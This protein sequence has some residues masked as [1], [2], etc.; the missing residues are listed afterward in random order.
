MWMQQTSTRV[1]MQK[2]GK[3]FSRKIFSAIEKGMQNTFKKIEF[4][5]LWKQT[6]NDFT[7]NSR[8]GVEWHS[9]NI[10]RRKLHFN[11]RSATERCDKHNFCGENEF[12]TN[13]YQQIECKMCCTLTHVW[14]DK[15]FI[16]FIP[17]FLSFRNGQNDNDFAVSHSIVAPKSTQYSFN[18]TACVFR[19]SKSANITFSIC[20]MFGDSFDMACAFVRLFPMRNGFENTFECSLY[21]TIMEHITADL[22]MIVQSMVMFSSNELN[23]R[24]RFIF[25]RSIQSHNS[26]LVHVDIN[27]FSFSVAI[28]VGPVH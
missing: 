11:W 12:F 14:H 16:H 28:D 10:I 1:S 18:V 20:S 9:I 22:W 24:C 27:S 19:P 15:T 26:I 2:S 8:N 21:P 17:F 7:M 23:F 3:W 13:R 5:Q 4:H 6:Q 25:A